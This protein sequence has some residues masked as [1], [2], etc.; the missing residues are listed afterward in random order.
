MKLGLFG[1]SFDPIHR[2]HVAHARAALDSLGLDRVLFLP[3]G[4]PPHKVQS[5]L[6]PAWSRFA[7][8]ELALLD[9]DNLE[10]S[11]LEISESE[12]SFTV[13][14]LRHFAGRF[15]GAELHLLLGADSFLDLPN[16][17]SWTEITELATL[18]VFSRPGVDA[19]SGCGE[20]HAELIRRGR[21]RWVAN[22]PLDISATE[23]RRC[24]AAAGPVPADWL[25][26]RVLRYVRKYSLYR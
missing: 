23:I 14:S 9:E 12:P 17:R 5:R 11:P 19:E 26:P 2:G 1:G 15:S 22:P 18:V 25:D 20:A 10:T 3:T 7:M 16:W 6:A 4:R 13:D 21:V 8:V 24:L